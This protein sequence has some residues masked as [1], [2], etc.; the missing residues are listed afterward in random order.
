MSKQDTPNPV[1]VL[2]AAD[3]RQL[4]PTA[5]CIGLIER[6]MRTVSRGQ[7]NLPVR[8]AARIADGNNLL[9]VMPGY[10][11]E[12]ASTG[13]KVIAVYPEA[14]QTM[15]IDAKMSIADSVRRLKERT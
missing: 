6:T 1:L 10:L 13:A 11:A 9:A 12:P 2:S 5:D 15:H 8:I 7:S 14:E 4:V 3:V